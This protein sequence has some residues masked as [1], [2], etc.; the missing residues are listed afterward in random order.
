M[1]MIG[2]STTPETQATTHTITIAA[3]AKA[4]Y[5]LVADVTRWPYTFGPTVHAEVF[6]TDG[7]VERLRLWAFANGAVRTWTSRRRLDVDG[8]TVHFEQEKSA[9]PLVAMG[10]QWRIEVVGDSVTRVELLHHF[11]TAQPDAVD[12]VLRAVNDNSEA[13]LAA[14]KRT[15]ELGDEH[16]RLVLSFSDSVTIAA[17]KAAVYEFLRAADLWPQRLPHVARLE[18]T[19]AVTGVQSMEMDTRG[20]DGSVHTTHSVRVC[21]PWDRIVYKQTATPK[22]MAAHVG[23]W[24]VREVP[25]GVEATS[26]HTVVIRPEEITCVL[27]PE[28]TLDRARELIRTSL[29]ANSLTTLRCAKEATERD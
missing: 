9:A 6:E 18:L 12:F 3:P 8:L 13:E 1:D 16:D 24:T 20:P 2:S 22:I 19:E 26:H 7:S 29:G 4:V 17:S 5:D 10:G 15:A 23:H 25:G 21:F 11:R 14:L 28:G 27:G